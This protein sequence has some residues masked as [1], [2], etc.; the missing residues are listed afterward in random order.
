MVAVAGFGLIESLN[1]P[2]VSNA[3]SILDILFGVGYLSALGYGRPS[4]SSSTLYFS[5]SMSF[6]SILF[7]SSLLILCVVTL[8][9]LPSPPF[10]KL[11]YFASA[12][13]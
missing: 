1:L 7:V 10:M 5:R 6:G 4:S 3:Y 11:I 13:P 2:K 8:N 12:A 9:S